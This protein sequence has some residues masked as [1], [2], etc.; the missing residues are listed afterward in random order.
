MIAYRISAADLD[1]LVEAH[2]PGW[3]ARADQRIATFRAAKKFAESNSIWS[4]VK[5]VYMNLQGESKCIFCE[6]KLESTEFGTG[7]QAVEHFRPKGAV[8]AWKPS[9][10]LTG[11]GLKVT[12]PPKG[13]RGYYLLAYHTLNYASACIPCNSALKSSKFPITGHYDCL[14]EDP[15]ALLKEGPLLIY[16]LG[17]F[18]E[19]PEDLI[20]FYGVSPRAVQQAG[21]RRFRAL[22]TIEFFALDDAVGRKNLVLDRARI[23]SALYPQ[24]RTL[25]VGPLEDRPAAAAMVRAYTSPKAPH[26]NCARSFKRLYDASPAE[27]LTIYSDA[28]KFID[29]SS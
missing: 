25:A 3:R 4:E 7:E 13:A 26:A 24:L 27:A 6:R 23:I 12:A 17:D 11:Q 29:A 18:D 15:K 20:E 22:V 19:D 10:R 9:R 21:Y 8:T 5:P 14:G 28:W 16:A 2:K 1:Q